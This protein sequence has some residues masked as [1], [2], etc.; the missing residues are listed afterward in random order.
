MTSIPA[1]FDRVTVLLHW[2]IGVGII[3]IA[4][5]EILRGE[6]P[7][8]N[9]VREGLKF[10][11]NPAGTIIFALVLVRIVWRLSHPAPAEP[12]GTTAW[13]RRAAAASHLALYAAMIAIPL[14][15]IIFTF[16]RGRP[17]DFGLFQIA[18]PLNHVIGSATMKFLKG[19]H[20]WLGQA[21]LG[22]AFVHAA[23]ALWHHYVRKDDVLVR[24]LPNRND[25]LRS[26]DAAPPLSEAEGKAL[27]E[28]YSSY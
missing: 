27:A 3:L 15:G 18:Y 16:A 11:H 13:E 24:M 6:L 5:A 26:A 7:K 4:A 12:A 10:A 22:L 8:G 21:V 9:A 2:A 14:L 17:I 23:A 19:V 1:R 20:E 25:Q 28:K